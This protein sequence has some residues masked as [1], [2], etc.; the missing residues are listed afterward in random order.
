VHYD[1][2]LFTPRPPWAALVVLVPVVGAVAVTF[3]VT[4]CALEARGLGVPEV[5]DS[6]YYQGGGT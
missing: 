1:A 6:I 2:N 5:M 4:K 3:L